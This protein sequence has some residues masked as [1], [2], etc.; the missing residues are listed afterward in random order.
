MF[1]LYNKELI[2]KQMVNLVTCHNSF[3]PLVTKENKTLL[4]QLLIQ[5][6]LAPV[7]QSK[8]TH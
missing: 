6:R 8:N 1:L 2:G 7:I 4:A 5:H 3:P